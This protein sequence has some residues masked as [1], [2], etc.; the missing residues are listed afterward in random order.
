MDIIIKKSGLPIYE[1]VYRQVRSQILNQG[2]VSETELPS[3]RMLA[4]E[5]G[6]SVITIR[7]AY[8]LL[9]LE[10][11]IESVPGKGYYV[12]QVDYQDIQDKVKQDIFMELKQL[13]Q[14]AI[15]NHLS[16]TTIFKEETWS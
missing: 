10:E 3:I 9:I 1:Q 13:N 7:K 11:L 12:C 6:V 5:L 8:E 14:K 4:Q 15:E 2:I 16:L